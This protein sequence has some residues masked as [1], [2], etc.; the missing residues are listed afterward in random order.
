MTDRDD[1]M[2]WRNIKQARVL[3]GVR[4]VIDE[5]E[6]E[7]RWLQL[8]CAVLEHELDRVQNGAEIFSTKMEVDGQ[9]QSS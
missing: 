3:V 6:M 1:F 5:L 7:K 4:M 8:Y 9:C 2:D